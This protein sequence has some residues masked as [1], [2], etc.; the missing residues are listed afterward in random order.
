MIMNFEYEL[1]RAWVLDEDD[2]IIGETNFAVP[3][4]WLKELY[5]KTYADEY[6]SFD[7]FMEV[8]DPEA[9]GEY[10]YREAIKD[11]ALVEDLGITM[12]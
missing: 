11:N 1:N 7:E 5:D 9:E 10:I 4:G 12:Y 6:N 2:E 8:Y 3:A